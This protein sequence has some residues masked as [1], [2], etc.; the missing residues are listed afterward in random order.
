MSYSPSERPNLPRG[1]L[2][3]EIAAETSTWGSTPAPALSVHEL[4]PFSPRESP[5]AAADPAPEAL[6]EDELVHASPAGGIR[7]ATT[8]ASAA[9]P[10][11]GAEH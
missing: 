5:R 9:S 2:E 10:A 7:A 6:I 11:F 4:V 1:I 3:T 8:D